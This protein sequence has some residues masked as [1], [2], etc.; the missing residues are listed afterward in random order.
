MATTAT[1]S[2]TLRRSIGAAAAR[3]Q[4]ALEA[5]KE[6]SPPPD[7][8]EDDIIDEHAELSTLHMA[9]LKPMT[10]LQQLHDQ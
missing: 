4:R 8:F 9:I 6:Y 7:P 5:A 3:L 1:K 2:T 10:K